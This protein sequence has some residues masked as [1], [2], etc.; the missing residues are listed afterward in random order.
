MHAY[1]AGA[2]KQLDCPPILAGGVADHVH[3]LARHGRTI[4][5][6]DWVKELKRVSND[7]F[8]QQGSAYADFQWQ[9]GYA[10]FSVSHSN[11]DRVILYIENQ[12]EHHRRRSFQDELRMLLRKHNVEWDE[13][14]VWD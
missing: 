5:Q 4:T 8:K 7:W 3:L 10:D 12:E 9:N 14:Y 13:K 2:S 11:L 6:A 1:L